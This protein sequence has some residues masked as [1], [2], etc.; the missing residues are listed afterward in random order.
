[1][2]LLRVDRERYSLMSRGITEVV[3][4]QSSKRKAPYISFHLGLG[5]PDQGPAPRNKTKLKPAL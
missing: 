5:P 3:I 1:M 2:E 4:V